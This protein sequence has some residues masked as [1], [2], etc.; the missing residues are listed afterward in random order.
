MQR[1]PAA[2]RREVAA[3][4]I[5]TAVVDLR[6]TATP[7]L[8]HEP[9]WALVWFDEVAAVYSARPLPPSVVELRSADSFA[10]VLDALRERLPPPA[11]ARVWPARQPPLAPQL[12]VFD[13]VMLAGQRELAASW[14]APIARALADD[15]GVALRQAALAAATGDRQAAVAHLSRGLEADPGDARL[16]L[17]LGEQ[18]FR[19]DRLE[20]ARERLERGLAREPGSAEGWHLLGRIAVRE[21]DLT[22][23]EPHFARAARLAPRRPLFRIDLARVQARSGRHADAAATLDEGL[24]ADPARVEL[25]VERIELEIDAGRADRARELFERARRAAPDDPRLARL[26]EKLSTFSR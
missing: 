2:W 24:A 22:S 20:Q 12:A 4:D 10:R 8:L 16:L 3:W 26:A 1:D 21:G 15:P 9:G 25:W 11:S 18:L 7:L 6:S 19:L 14:L 23:A 13:F 17:E 5:R